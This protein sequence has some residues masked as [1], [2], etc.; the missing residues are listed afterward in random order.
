[1]LLG[2]AS[3]RPLSN[4]AAE[5]RATIPLRRGDVPDVSAQTDSATCAD[6]RRPR[7][8]RA[9]TCEPTMRTDDAC[10][11][12]KALV[13]H[14]SLRRSW[15]GACHFGARLLRSSWGADRKISA[16]P[17]AQT[18]VAAE[19]ERRKPGKRGFEHVGGGV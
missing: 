12:D 1:M 9:R 15:L 7:R 17:A 5:A 2:R 11:P 19:A 6:Q 10:A 16:E 8:S 14:L 4:D 3:Q 18:S 13:R